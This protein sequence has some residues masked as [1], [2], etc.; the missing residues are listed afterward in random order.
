MRIV[1]CLDSIN[2]VGGIQRVTLIKANALATLPENEVWIIVA[3]NSGKRYSPLSSAIH[4]LDLEINYYKDDWKSR[5]HVLKGIFFKRNI[6]KKRLAEVLKKILPDIVIGV[7]QSEKF[8]LPRI[9]GSWSTVREFHFCKDY[10]HRTATGLFEKTIALIGDFLDNRFILRRY[11]RIV[12]LTHEDLE[13][14]WRGVK[15]VTVIP[16]P[17]WPKPEGVSSLDP[18]RVLAVGRLSSQKNFASLI[19]AYSIVAKRFPDWRLDIFGEGEERE[20]LTRLVSKLA[21]DGKVNLCGNTIDVQ[22][23]MLSSSIF[24]L[25]S[26]FEGFAM[27]LLEAICCGLPCVCY[28]CPCGPKDIFTD[29]VNG[30]LVPEGNEELLAEKICYLIENEAERRR[31]GHEAFKSSLKFELSL[32]IQMWMTLFQELSA[33]VRKR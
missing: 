1:Y 25:S 24:A 6:H 11:D 19:R 9:K 31:M 10:R 27:V 30:F 15:N 14:N 3:D 26:I 16:N 20:G 18:K 33:P 7:G 12:V 8:F 13:T 29:G 21:L 32:I 2:G 23:E 22:K 4:F 28:S 5:V 17:S